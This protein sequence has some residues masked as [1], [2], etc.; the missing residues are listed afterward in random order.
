MAIKAI[1]YI[2]A[3]LRHPTLFSAPGSTVALAHEYCFGVL[4]KK[5]NVSDDLQEIK[6]QGFIYPSR[7]TFV[8]KF[9]AAVIIAIKELKADDLK[10]IE[11]RSLV[12]LAVFLL[13]QHV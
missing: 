6:G 13:N 8:H 1:R 4:K 11:R 3:Y 9:T 5:A 2:L 10:N 7:I 12:R